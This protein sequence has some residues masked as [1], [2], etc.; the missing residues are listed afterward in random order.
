[1]SAVRPKA[2]IKSC[3]ADWR[4]QERL[5]FEFAG[6]GEHACFYVEKHDL[7][8][9]D[10]A[11]G[12]AHAY[13]VELVQIGYC[14]LKDKHGI[15]CQWFSVPTADDCWRLGMQGVH[16]IQI[17][18]HTHKLRRG[19]HAANRFDLCLRELG[20]GAHAAIEKL[21]NPYPNYF[22]PQRV[23]PSNVEQALDWLGGGKWGSHCSGRPRRRGNRRSRKNGRKG[24][25]ISVL[26]SV[27]F[28]EVLSLR[29]AQGN[30]IEGIDGDVLDGG[31]PTGPLWGR[32]RSPVTGDAA[33]IERR[34]LAT[35]ADTCDA[36]EYAGVNQARRR[37]V[38]TPRCFEIMQSRQ[39]CCVLSFELPVGAYATAMLEHKLDLV[40]VS[41][42]HE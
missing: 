11:R 6:G 13:G 35:H 38:V 22:G 20:D 41:N 5:G 33:E 19:Q 3:L 12:L 30:Y 14:G 25:H 24:W 28:N 4:V 29:V 8:T 40:D 15:T 10:V 31:V 37:L 16:C 39:E 42:R 9:A 32:G 17:E 36:L 34:A 27:L 2:S 21:A 23:S 1:M 26:R 18:R 7:N